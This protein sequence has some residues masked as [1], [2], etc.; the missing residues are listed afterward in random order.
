MTLIGKVYKLSNYAELFGAITDDSLKPYN[1]DIYST[2]SI[3][4]FDVR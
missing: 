2:S 1:S 3:P 4:Y